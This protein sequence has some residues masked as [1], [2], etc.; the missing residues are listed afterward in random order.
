MPTR[1]RTILTLIMSGIIALG[2]CPPLYAGEPVGSVTHVSGSLG[3]RKGDGSIKFLSINS[4][5]EEGD[6]LVTEKRTYARIK[7]RDNSEVTLKP[8][9]Q[10][11]IEQFSHSKDKPADDK[12]AYNLVKGGLRAVTGQIGKRGN[13]DSYQMKTPTATIGIRGT[14]YGATYCQADCGKLPSGLYVDVADGKIV[15]T[16]R[17]GSQTLGA[18][19]Y[20]H[21]PSATAPPVIL[22]KNP[23]IS[24][25]TP[26]SSVSGPSKGPSPPT[27]GEQ[28]KKDDCEVR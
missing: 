13:Q 9:T 11:K 19:Q 26:P 25:F 8:N 18:G 17:G 14:D 7:F 10:F 21:V 2:I 24:T 12:A 23:G 5:V 22:P 1:I 20:G 16:N 4:P 6:M 27:G 28:G 15:V 3:A